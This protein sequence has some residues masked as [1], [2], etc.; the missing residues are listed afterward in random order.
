MHAILA[1][2]LFGLVLVAVLTQP[3]GLSI[4]W[5]AFG[6]GVLAWVLGVVN[7]HDVLEVVGIVWD[8]TLTFVALIIIS[9][10]LDQVGMFQWAALKMARLAGTS[11]LR[12]FLWLG[13]LGA[14]VSLFFANDGAA[15]ILTP[16]VYEQARALKLDPKATLALIMTSGFIADT[17]SVPLVI[18][19][20]VNIVSA[21]Y[22]HLGFASYA[23]RMVPVDAVALAASLGA[24]YLL[25]RRVLPV[26]VATSALAEP[27]TVILDHDVFRLA[28]WILALL[29]AGYFASQLLHWP[30]SV[31][32]G[33]AAV[34]LLLKARQSPVLSV[35]RL[36]RDAPWRIV[37]FS[38]GMY[39]VVFGLR[40]AGLTTYLS[41]LILH[42]H[43]YGGLIV[44]TGALAALLSA[45]TNNLPSVMIN[46]LAI[47]GAGLPPYLAHAAAYANVVG[48][49]LGTKITPIGSLAT[50]LWLHVL[51][52][53]GIHISW[54]YYMKVGVILT[55][56]V[57]LATLLGLWGWL[58]WLS[59]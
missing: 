37:I 23:I 18:S 22:F 55:I 59:S 45:I 1:V 43:S 50:L 46:A 38:L 21:D 17:T 7:G 48:C 44:G 15:L 11:G 8:A 4:G 30:V 2:V 5:S 13:V 26:T 56:P 10:V 54:G 31:F 33:L 40:D 35:R 9:M 20:L 27:S 52:R 25:Y 36:L 47:Q 6:G 41:H 14:M 58:H 53:R 32:S 19:N 57:L 28:W 49:D 34:A 3:W 42:F 16:L 24:L 12:L 29:L 39:V 51:D